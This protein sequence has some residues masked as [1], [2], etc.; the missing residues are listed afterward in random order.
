MIQERQL[1]R[2][3]KTN[4]D[5]LRNGDNEIGAKKRHAFLDLLLDANQGSDSMSLDQIRQEV[6]TFMFEVNNSSSFN[7]EMSFVYLFLMIIY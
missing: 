2:K 5:L 1:A 4:R 7:D 3:K 6:D